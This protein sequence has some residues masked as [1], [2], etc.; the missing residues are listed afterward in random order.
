M[1]E[2][3]QWYGVFEVREKGGLEQPI[4][5][6]SVYKNYFTNLRHGDKGPNS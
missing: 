3:G 1:N 2:N 6:D 5:V 4:E